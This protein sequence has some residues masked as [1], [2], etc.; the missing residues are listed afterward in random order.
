MKQ[1]TSLLILILFCVFAKAQSTTK[2]TGTVIDSKT[3][4]PLPGATIILNNTEGAISDADGKFALTT[5]AAKGNVK[6]SISYLGYTGTTIDV[7]LNR[8]IVDVGTVKLKENVHS[9][10]AVVVKGRSAI[11]E[12]KGD[13]ISFNA[14][15]V[16][17]KTDA[18]GLNIIKK[19]PGFTYKNDKIETQGEQVKKIYVDGKPYFEDDP[20]SALNS[21][22]ADIIKNI[23]I[24][25]DYGEVAS[26]TGYASGNSV[27][28]MNIVTT[29]K[30]KSFRNYKIGI[31]SDRHYQLE[32]NT[33]ISRNNF[34]LSLMFE[35]N[36]IN[37]SNAD[38]SQFKSL[39]SIIASKV[40]GD[41]M[42]QPATFGEKKIG[43]FGI[44]YNHRITPKT[45]LSV[46]YNTAK[47]DNKT[48]QFTNQNYQ[49]TWFYDITDSINS[50]QRLHKLNLK[51]TSQPNTNNKFIFSQ[52]GM[53]IKGESD[54]TSYSKGYAET[55]ILNDSDTEQQKTTDQ[56]YT[57]SMFI[58]LHNFGNSGRSLTTLANLTLK[59]SNYNQIFRN[60]TNRYYSN[61]EY[62]INYNNI[63]YTDI[64]KDTDNSNNSAMLRISYKEP[65]DILTNINFVVKSAYNWGNNNINTKAYDNTTNSYS[66]ANRNLS[67][68]TESGYW[69][70]RAEIGYSAFDLNYVVNVGVAYEN[71]ITNN[72]FTNPDTDNT[73]RVYHNVLPVIFG[74]YFIS[75]NKDITFYIRSNTVVPTAEQ[76]QPVVNTSD[77]VQVFTGNPDLK[78]GLQH[79]AMV[80]YTHTLSE[81]SRFLTVY[82]FLKYGNNIVGTNTWFTKETENIYGT[83]VTAGTK[84][85]KPVN[86]NGYT[87]VISGIDYSFPLYPI[88]CK[89]NTGVKYTFSALPTVLENTDITSKNHSATLS[90][91]LVSNISEKI[92]FNIAN[93][94]SFNHA[95][96]SE[97]SNYT[98]FMSQ[99][100]NADINLTLFKRYSLSTQYSYVHHNYFGKTDNQEYNLLNIK[101][102]RTFLKSNRLGLYVEVYDLLNQ[103]KGLAFNLHE[104]YKETVQSNALNRY[105]MV[106]LSFRM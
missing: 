33:M 15:A 5:K 85:T 25:D 73:N 51:L 86:L 12:Q 55:S 41:L 52:N 93:Y 80:K 3:L 84:V 103:N 45:D 48:Y 26:F 34:D 88:K 99:E 29:K 16:K 43:N 23:E 21:L 14:M 47:I 4:S 35:R 44:N 10:D 57:N 102:G 81:K 74:K 18:K 27:K 64:N 39:E 32:G 49:D 104:T 24:F 66:T 62:N 20:K 71:T 6:L 98:D 106:S 11:A 58:W 70:N 56:Y 50:K 90:M 78:I 7:A 38:L 65:I 105:L 19:L 92:D 101:V 72:T 28:A 54:I 67:G 76:L 2:V 100:V 8:A 30:K 89:V 53:L 87:N 97:N 60:S 9:I 82:G 37:Q 79:I 94:T 69:S 83:E 96:N 1:L 17:V 59:E 22:P 77:P 63:T 68:T 95:Y 75:G 61:N 31:G 42:S 46:N 13:T 91:A 40:A 36:N